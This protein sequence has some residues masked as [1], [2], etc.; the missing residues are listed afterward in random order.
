MTLGIGLFAK[1]LQP[2]SSV[3]SILSG[4]TV[5]AEEIVKVSFLSVLASYASLT[6][7]RII[8]LMLSPITETLQEIF[9]DPYLDVIVTK[10]IGDIGLGVFW[11]VLASSLVEAGH[12]S[13]SGPMSTF[14]RG[15][16]QQSPSSQVDN[17]HISSEMNSESNR[18]K[19]S[20]EQTENLRSV[21]VSWSSILKTGASL[22]LG[23]AMMSLGGPMFFGASL[24][25]GFSAIKSFSKSFEVK[26]NIVRD[27]A[28]STEAESIMDINAEVMSDAIQWGMV[29][30]IQEIVKKSHVSLV[31]ADVKTNPSLSL[32]D[33]TAM[34]WKAHKKTG[35]LT[36]VIP[37]SALAFT[38]M[39]WLVGA[40]SLVVGG[41]TIMAKR[42]INFIGSGI[43]N[44]DKFNDLQDRVLEQLQHYS[45]TGERLYNINTIGSYSAPV[46]RKHARLILYEIF[47]DHDRSQTVYDMILGT[48]LTSFHEV[49][50][51]ANNKGFILK[52]SPTEWFSMV[53]ERGD[54]A[55]S[56]LYVRVE[57]I[58]GHHPSVKIVSSLKRAVRGKLGGFLDGCSIC[59]HESH[60]LDFELATETGDMFGFDLVSD[61]VEFDKALE[62]V[63]I[64]G[65]QNRDV[66]LRWR[67]TLPNCQREFETAYINILVSHHCPYCDSYLNQKALHAAAEYAFDLDF[68]AEERIWDVFPAEKGNFH[69]LTS[70][71]S[72][73]ETLFFDGNGNQIKVALERQ[74]RQH[75]DT[76]GGYN[77]YLGINGLTDTPHSYKAWRRLIA[78]DRLKVATFKKYNKFGYYL[79]VARYKV[80]RW[81]MQEFI[82]QEFKRQTGIDLPSKPH[83]DV[84]RYLG[85]NL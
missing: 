8:S 16:Q 75:E 30:N 61:E 38:P 73:G 67:H 3:N 5:F 10:I 58:K 76:P 6:S 7:W 74:G 81:Q 31:P 25:M 72:Y 64:E 24:V 55:I 9:V 23:T 49:R 2:I 17:Q 39:M 62:K 63:Q 52:T 48:A 71:D 65:R 46:A 51:R 4:G 70:L 26:K 77:Y 37:L 22:L 54:Q 79:I 50:R 57:C 19:D 41:I 32:Y 14:L 1:A 35:A 60:T 34:W 36:V 66:I 44:I 11:Q 59:Y 85:S 53:Q 80:S 69:Q 43:K 29:E 68:K 33:R 18:I 15:N 56:T 21:K 78:N 42:N 40:A 83:F 27:T 28:L 84:D 13:L 82:V 12:E 20:I 47:R 45:R